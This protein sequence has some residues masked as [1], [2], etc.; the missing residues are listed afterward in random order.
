MTSPPHPVGAA[1]EAPPLCVRQLQAP[2][3]ELLA[4]DAVLFLEVRDD[5]LLVAAQPAGERPDAEAEREG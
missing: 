2:V 5:G 3:A 4:E 1:G